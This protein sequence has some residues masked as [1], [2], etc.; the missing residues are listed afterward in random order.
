MA[1][2]GAPDSRK[3]IFIQ[4]CR[5]RLDHLVNEDRS[6]PHTNRVMPQTHHYSTSSEIVHFNA[7]PTFRSVSSEGLGFAPDSD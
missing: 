1:A 6:Q 7:F 2:Q 3:L 4:P 5:R